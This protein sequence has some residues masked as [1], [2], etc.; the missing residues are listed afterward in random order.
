MET[1]WPS[2]SLPIYLYFEI[3][4]PISLYHCWVIQ[5]NT[6]TKINKITKGLN[7][8][9]VK[10]TNNVIIFL[11]LYIRSSP[12]RGYYQ[13]D[14]FLYSHKKILLVKKLE[15]ITNNRAVNT[16]IKSIKK[17]QQDRVTLHIEGR[18][19]PLCKQY[20][21]SISIFIIPHT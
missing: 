20:S 17:L 18:A 12:S 7:I 13:S 1:F 9:F 6:K 10:K 3:K 2:L 14:R 8:L 19:I 15:Q 21:T 4:L 5:N 11:L 16:Q